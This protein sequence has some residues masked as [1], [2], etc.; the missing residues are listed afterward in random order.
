MATIVVTGAAGFIGSHLCELLLDEN[1]SVIA[2]DNF[3]PFYDR[4]EKERNLAILNKK[5]GWFRF[6]SINIESGQELSSIDNGPIDCVIHLAAKAGVQPSLKDPAGY[7]RTNIAGTQNILDFMKERDIHKYIFASSS[8]VYG[9]NKKIPFSETDDVNNPISP[10]ASTKKSGEL[11]AYTYHHLYNLDVVNL[12]FFTVYGPRQRPDLA[13]HKFFKLIHDNKPITIYGDGSTARD[14][15]FIADTV[16]GIF[17]AFNY[18]MNNRNVFEIINL[19]N[20]KPVQLLHLV[21]SIYQVIG[22]EPSLQYLPMQPGDVNI[23][24][25]DISK[26]NRLLHYQPRIGLME[27]LRLFNDWFNTVNQVTKIQ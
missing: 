6:Y 7:V 2:V 21:E 18:V 23:T 13:I 15:T 9:N 10:Y 17:S 27:G 26:A 11:L 14:Y 1:H 22:K 20:N 24:Y 12:R 3:D 5:P 19:G 16:S 25:A 8:S 4:A